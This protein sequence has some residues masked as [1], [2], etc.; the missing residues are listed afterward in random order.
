M[1]CDW[2]RYDRSVS[3]TQEAEGAGGTAVGAAGE[4]ALAVGIFA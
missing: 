4:V 2:S 3:L 1:S